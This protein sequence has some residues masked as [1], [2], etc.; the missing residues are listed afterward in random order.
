MD[1]TIFAKKRTANDGRTFYG[2]IARL[3]NVN[4]GETLVAGVKFRDEC[5]A[6][7]PEKCPCNIVVDKKKANLSEKLFTAE[8]GETRKGY[9]LWVSEWTPGKEYVDTSLDEYC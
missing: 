5:G 7:K 4:T 8:N 3:T 1:L 2:Y 9:T 6:P